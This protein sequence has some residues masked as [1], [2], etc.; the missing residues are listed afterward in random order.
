MRPSAAGTG[1]HSKYPSAGTTQRRSLNALR[2]AGF[3]AAVSTRAL[4]IRAPEP[5]SFDQDGTSPQ[6]SD[7]TWRVISPVSRSTRSSTLATSSVGATFHDGASASAVGHSEARSSSA[8]SGGVVVETNRPHMRLILP[9]PDPAR[10]ASRASRI[11]YPASVSRATHRTDP[12][13]RPKII[14]R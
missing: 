2:N 11:P 8:R 7:R 14:G 6:R 1:R 4:I 12:G 9:A 3:S 5:G 13:R 10:H